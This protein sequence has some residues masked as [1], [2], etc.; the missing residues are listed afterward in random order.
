MA[1]LIKN[2]ETELKARE[3]ASL[4]GQ[5]ITS[6]IDAALDRAVAEAQPK[7]QRT[8]E[9]MNAATDELWARA[10]KSGPQPPVTKAE[11]DEIN[12]A[13]GF[14]EDDDWSSLI[15]LRSSQ[16]PCENSTVRSSWT[17]S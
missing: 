10:G 14:V 1:I 17:R 11:W 3:L 6:V 5:S 2:P 16:S 4:R 7:R 12:E 15:L 8:L 13:P 9:E